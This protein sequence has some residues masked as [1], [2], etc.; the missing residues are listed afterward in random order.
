[1]GHDVDV[2]D[3]SCDSQG[4]ASVTWSRWLKA[5]GTVSPDG[6]WYDADVLLRRGSW[7]V[8]RAHENA[9]RSEEQRSGRVVH[10]EAVRR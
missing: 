2:E 6:G 3:S 8:G 10:Q 1:M 9:H 7:D 5:E 4:P